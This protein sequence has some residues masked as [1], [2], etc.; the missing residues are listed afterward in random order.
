MLKGSTPKNI[1]FHRIT[2]FVTIFS[3]TCTYQRPW[4]TDNLAE[5]TIRNNLDGPFCPM[6]QLEMKPIEEKQILS[7]DVC[8]PW[9]LLEFYGSSVSSCGYFWSAHRKRPNHPSCP[10]TFCLDLL[11][12]PYVAIDWSSSRLFESEIG[13]TI[14]DQ[15]NRCYL[16]YGGGQTFLSFF[17][18]FFYRT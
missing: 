16:E 10:A 13:L 12:V 6:E 2:H 8:T 3:S 18:A 1:D 4:S 11:I 9:L 7:V 17:D 5:T 15:D 14:T